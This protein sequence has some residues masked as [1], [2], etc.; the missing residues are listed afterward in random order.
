[1]LSKSGTQV[2]VPL[3]LRG[4]G[5]HRLSE[6]RVQICARKWW[7][8]ASTANTWL[9]GQGSERVGETLALFCWMLNLVLGQLRATLHSWGFQQLSQTLAHPRFPSTSSTGRR[10]LNSAQRLRSSTTTFIPPPSSDTPLGSSSRRNKKEPT[11]KEKKLPNSLPPS[12]I[13]L[14]FVHPQAIPLPTSITA[15]LN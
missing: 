10:P 5:A 9:I 11:K 1:M 12:H 6:Q 14:F 4:G 8:S 2:P 3:G 13:F 15:S 7:M